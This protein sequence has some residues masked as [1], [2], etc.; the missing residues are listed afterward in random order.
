MRQPLTLVLVL[1]ACVAATATAQDSVPVVRVV[2]QEGMIHPVASAIL[3]KAMTTARENGENLVIIELDTP[4]GLVEPA[5]DIVK[6][7]LN[8]PVPVCVYVSPRGAHAASA[9]FFILLASDVAAMA[10][11]TRTGA[12]S[13]IQL[14]GENR[15]DDVALKKISEDLSALMRSTART[16]RGLRRSS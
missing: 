7:I 6:D 16:R 3:A 4:G 8:S 9:G 2:E 11:V 1:L 10:P 14:G 5:E 13:P 15:Q 12:A